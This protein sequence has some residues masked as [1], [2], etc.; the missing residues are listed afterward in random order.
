MT[1][2]F[3]NTEVTDDL[4]KRSFGGMKAIFEWAQERTRREELEPVNPEL[5][6][7]GIGAAMTN[8]TELITQYI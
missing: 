4:D 8:P 3:S 6:L 2:V 7:V 5:G 1:I